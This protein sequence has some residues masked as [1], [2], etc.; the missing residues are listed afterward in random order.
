M[1]KIKFCFTGLSLLLL[2]FT[3]CSK[4]ETGT[5]NPQKTEM[6]KLSFA[7]ILNDLVANNSSLKQSLNDLPM[8]SDGTPAYVEVI[9]SQGGNQVVGTTAN[10]LKV[11][12]NPN[13]ADYDNDGVDEYFTN[14]SASLELT[15]G[16]Y[17]LDF[18]KVYD[19][20][21]TLLWIA[22]RTGDGSLASYVQHPLPMDINLGAGVKK[23]VDVDVLCYDHRMANQYGYLFFD[24]EETQVIDFC[25][26]GNYCDANGRHFPAHFSVDVWKYADG[27]KGD[28]L[29]NDLTNTVA[30]DQNGDYAG[31]TVCV[32]LPDGAGLD[33][34]YFEI[35]LLDSDAYGDVA[36]T[37]IR[38][39][40]IN[41]I[42]VRNFFDGDNNLEYYHFREGCESNDTPPIF[43]QPGVTN[44]KS[45][46]DAT[47]NSGVVALAFLS[48]DQTNNT[49]DATIL[50][51]KL[52][53]N[54]VHPQHIHGFADKHNSTC[55]PSSVAGA[56]GIISLSEG[57]PY[58]GPVLLG[59]DDGSGTYPTST[60]GGVVVYEHT[61]NLGSGGV[62]T[63]ATLLPLENRAV[64]LHGMTVN[65]TY[66]ATIPVACGEFSKTSD[67]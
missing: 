47:N 66:D 31:S 58:Y 13:P 17:T 59:L 62:P 51:T 60:S 30:I 3:S 39:G 22:P 35:T 43:D 61:F 45:C 55:P 18:F 48:L 14:E 50:A 8:C 37:V 64:V 27:V 56:D 52:E 20:N 46:L 42:I 40:V 16:T 29:Y 9:L 1:K 63:A 28:Q 4:D 41:D 19:A 49:L 25:I 15:P 5:Q 7:T 10:P 21:N 38:K 54:K 65:S 11:N 53:P 24:I 32:A 67:F 2:L 36:N 57:L 44:Y 33:E 34:Y 23:Y 12:V 26:F 6:A